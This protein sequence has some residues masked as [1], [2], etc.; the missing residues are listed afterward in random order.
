MSCSAFAV[1]TRSRCWRSMYFWRINPSTES[2][3]L[4]CFGQLFV[5]DEFSRCLHREE[6]R[7]FCVT[8]RRFRRLGLQRGVERFRL[9]LIL[10]AQR[11]QRLA[12]RGVVSDRALAVNLPPT[13]RGH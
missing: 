10:C 3:L 2:A 5:L 4:H 9:A 7:R 1:G 6:Q 12:L 13:S 8:R 11:R